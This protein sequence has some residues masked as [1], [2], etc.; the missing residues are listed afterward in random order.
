MEKRKK[1][2]F[3]LSST[4]G[5]AERMTVNIAKMLPTDKFEVQL[6]FIWKRMAL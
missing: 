6:L 2:L 4:T 3:F 5:G 1:V